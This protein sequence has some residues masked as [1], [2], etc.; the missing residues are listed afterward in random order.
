ME[1]ARI[2]EAIAAVIRDFPFPSITARHGDAYRNVA[3]VVTRYVPNGGRILDFGA[4]AG[5]KIAVTARLGYTCVAA[6]DLGDD[7]HNFGDNRT[8]IFDFLKRNGIEFAV[9]AE[10]K[11]W[12]FPPESFDMVMAHDVLEHLHD[13]PRE[14]LNL[15][16]GSLKPGGHL[17]ITVPNAANLRK[18]IDLLRGRTNLPRFEVYFWSHPRWRGHVREYVEGDLRELCASMGLICSELS[19]RDQ[20]LHKARGLLRPIFLALSWIVPSFKDTV[21]LVARKPVNWVPVP[22]AEPERLARI[23]QTVSHYQY[24]AEPTSPPKP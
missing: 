22:P 10:S 11:P 2:Q 4:G 20:M 14:L 1:S 6:D 8:R 24:V 23:Q 18:R 5:D 3:D 7:W 19:H 12:P 16:V 9:T 15:L 21:Q 17:L 13:S